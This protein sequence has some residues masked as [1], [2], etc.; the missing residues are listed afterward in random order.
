MITHRE[1]CEGECVIFPWLPCMV[2]DSP[3]MESAAAGQDRSSKSIVLWSS[4]LLVLWH[5]SIASSTTPADEAIL[6][7]LPCG[8]PRP[9]DPHSLIRPLPLPPARPTPSKPQ[10]IDKVRSFDKGVHSSGQISHGIFVEARQCAYSR[11]GAAWPVA[12][13][14]SCAPVQSTGGSSRGFNQKAE[15]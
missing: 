7:P 10:A 4:M 8:C 1:R 12:C 13:G 2:E 15:I 9:L 3:C 14:A 6:L 11:V 5:C